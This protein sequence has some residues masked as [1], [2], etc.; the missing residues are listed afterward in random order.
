MPAAAIQLA[1]NVWR[2]PTVFWDLVNTMVFKED[3]GRVTLVDTGIKTAP[4]RILAALQQ[5]GSGPADVTRIVLTHA[6]G[7]HAGGVAAL[8]QQTGAAVLVH[9]EDAPFVRTGQTPDLDRSLLLGRLLRTGGKFGA[10]EVAEELTDGQLLDVGGGLRVHHTPGHT[11]GHVALLHEP[12]R[13][14]VT[15]DSIWNVRARMTWSFAAVCNNFA[16]T[17]QT[18]HVLAELD[19]DTVAFTHGP[20]IRDDAREAVRSFL[21]RPKRFRGGL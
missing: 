18:A 7:D 17:Q 21:R 3:D 10:T 13:L 16:L 2:V 20:E 6:H 14:L 19:Y 8:R 11:P 9:V 12:S 15:G 4:G 5:I 1:P